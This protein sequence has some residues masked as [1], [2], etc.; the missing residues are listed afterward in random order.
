VRTVLIILCLTYLL[1][2]GSWLKASL[3]TASSRSDTTR[4]THSPGTFDGYPAW[5]PDGTSIAFVSDR[6]GNLDVWVMQADGS[7]PTNL[8]VGNKDANLVFDWDPGGTRMVFDSTGA[9]NHYSDI[10]VVNS[11]GTNAVNLT[12]LLDLGQRQMLTSPKWSPDGELLAFISRADAGQAEFA[13][14]IIIET[15]SW[16]IAQTIPFEDN[17]TIVSP[18]DWSPDGQSVVV[19]LTEIR[20]KYEFESQLWVFAV[21]GSEARDISYRLRDL[22]DRDTMTLAFHNPDWSPNGDRIVFSV[23]STGRGDVYLVD[24][25][26]DNLMRLTQDISLEASGEPVWSPQGDQIAFSLLYDGAMDVWVINADGTN[27]INLTHSDK[28]TDLRPSWSP[29][30]T[31]LTYQSGLYGD[32]DVWVVD[33]NGS[34]PVNLTGTH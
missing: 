24:K 30:G 11:D 20:E 19:P 7:N 33:A 21:D 32:A 4:T 34:N 29:D 18:L 2:G 26:G 16:R 27:P 8:T 14:L 12:E 13:E 25:D 22:L 10:W 5:S 3:D 6:A 15:E 23:S 1:L 31:R 17:L 9:S 28:T